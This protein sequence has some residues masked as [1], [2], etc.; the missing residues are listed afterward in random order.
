M[1]KDKP[2]KAE[3][4]AARRIVGRE[5]GK[6]GGKRRKEVL[7]AFPARRREIARLGGLAKLGKKHKPKIN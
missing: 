1:S 2:T 5:N 4:D 6:L 7:D 3:I